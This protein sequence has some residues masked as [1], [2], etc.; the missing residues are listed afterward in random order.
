MSMTPLPFEKDV[1]I[2]KIVREDTI[3]F[4]YKVNDSMTDL[5]AVLVRRTNENGDIEIGESYSFHI[6][7]S[8][9]FYVWSDEEHWETSNDIVFAYSPKVA[10]VEGD[11]TQVDQ[12]LL[13]K[14][15]GVKITDTLTVN[16][17]RKQELNLQLMWM[18]KDGP[19]EVNL[20]NTDGENKISDEM[21]QRAKMQAEKPTPVYGKKGGLKGVK[22]P[23][24]QFRR[25]DIP[26]TGKT[27]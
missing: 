21:I 18:F 8:D 16:F 13:I 3:F 20:N 11:S 6:P 12:A 19:R 14:Y 22:L 27:H 4:I 5:C 17:D 15:E 23:N 9:N 1:I 24:G 25:I 7:E 2:G 26:Y 10:Q